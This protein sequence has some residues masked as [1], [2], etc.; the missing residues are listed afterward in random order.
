MGILLLP[1]EYLNNLSAVIPVTILLLL[2]VIGYLTLLAHRTVRENTLLKESIADQ[3]HLLLLHKEYYETME[4]K[5]QQ[6]QALR[7]DLRHQFLLID[8]LLKNKQYAELASLIS[9]CQED[10][11]STKIAVFCPHPVIN[12]LATHYQQIAHQNGIL[13]DLRCDLA[14]E[15][16][17]TDSDLSRLLGNLLA[18]A[19]EA[20]LRVKTGQ[21]FIRIS[22]VQLG[23]TLNICVWN[24]TDATLTPNGATFISTKRKNRTG[25]GLF[26][27]HN[28][29]Q[30]Y[31][32]ETSTTWDQNTRTFC[33]KVSLAL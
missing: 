26:S 28:I 4:D 25:C 5:I 11:E 18:N 29:T 16:K 13:F 22:I 32:G 12:L 19:T 17:M 14:H 33:H 23:S 31:H 1:D 8:G 3:E 10:M 30:K 9:E 21:P 24:S 6:T 2:P 27:I 15:I 20:C 7:H